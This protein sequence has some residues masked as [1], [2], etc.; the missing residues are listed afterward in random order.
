MGGRSEPESGLLRPCAADLC[1]RIGN[2]SGLCR[3]GRSDRRHRPCAGGSGRRGS[4]AAGRNSCR[5]DDQCRLDAVVPRAAAIIT[6]IGAPLSHAAIV[7]REL[8]I[9]AVVGRGRRPPGSVRET[10]SSLTAVK[11]S[12][13]C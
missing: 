4:A 5:L 6:D 8:G 13:I 3:G 10:G 2:T 1:V 12:C 9:P 7:A 11:V